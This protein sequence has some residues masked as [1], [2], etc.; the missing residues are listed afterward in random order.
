MFTLPSFVLGYAGIFGLTRVAVGFAIA[1]ANRVVFHGANSFGFN[2]RFVD[3]GLLAFAG[4]ETQR[5]TS[6]NEVN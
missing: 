2:F 3:A 1:A 5:R 6:E 4:N